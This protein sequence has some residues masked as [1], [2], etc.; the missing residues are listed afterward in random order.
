MRRTLYATFMLALLTG[1]AS[2][3][4]RFTDPGGKVYY[5]ALNSASNSLK[6]E[7]NGKTYQGGFRIIEWTRAKAT[8]NAPGAEP[9]LCEFVIDLLRVRGSCTDLVGGDYVLQSR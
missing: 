5:G 4:L 8:L 3:P 6:A 2:E 7:I 9:L 1:C